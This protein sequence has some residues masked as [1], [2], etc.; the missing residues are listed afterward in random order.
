MNKSQRI[1]LDIN[2]E[3]I[4]KH[5]KVKLEQNVDSLEFLTM[6]IDTKDVYQ[7]F[8]ADYGVLVGRVI[9]NDGIGIP[10]AKISVFLPLADEDANDSEIVSFYPYKTPRDKNNQ[11]KRYNLLPRVA[12]TD[13]LT[14]ITSPKQP[15]G[16][17]PIKEEI[18]TNETFL[19][20]YKK[21]YKY[22]A[23]TNDFGDYM[24]FGVPVGVQT[25][26]LSVDITDI[27]KYSMTPASMVTNLGYSANLFTDDGSKIKESSDLNDLPNVETQEISVDIVPFWGDSENFII[28][29]TQQNFRI[30]STL[31]NTFTIF[32]SVFTD[33]DFAMWGEDYQNAEETYIL[34]HMMDDGITNAEEYS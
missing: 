28:G 20:V 27:G 10:N 8:N 24:I 13:P 4:D 18:V 15:F 30:R 34:Y 31:K 1:H 29:I 3:N 21:Y 6:N 26:H 32:G 16:S 11:G 9:A 17:F 33:G 2:S 19:N 12:K 7:D 25:I 23:L 22:T 5:L 14:N